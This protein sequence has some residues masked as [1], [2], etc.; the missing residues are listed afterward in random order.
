MLCFW[1]WILIEWDDGGTDRPF[2][3]FWFFFFFFFDRHSLSGFIGYLGETILAGQDFPVCP[4]YQKGGVL[5]IASPHNPA[6]SRKPSLV[7][8]SVL[9]SWSSCFGGSFLYDLIR[10]IQ[11]DVSIRHMC[12]SSLGCL[13]G[14]RVLVWKLVLR[15]LI[16]CPPVTV[17]LEQPRIRSEWTSRCRSPRSRTEAR[18]PMQKELLMGGSLSPEKPSIPYRYFYPW[19]YSCRE[20]AHQAGLEHTTSALT[21]WKLQLP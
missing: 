11:L 17:L 19:S 20:Y 10:H 16:V 3:F 12:L 9:R 6:Y 14:L 2:D 8:H 7:V 15:Y 18:E 1:S 5:A 21:P 4:G 13:C